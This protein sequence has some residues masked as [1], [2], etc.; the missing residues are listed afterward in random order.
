MIYEVKSNEKENRNTPNYFGCCSYSGF[1]NGFA[2]YVCECYGYWRNE[3]RTP[4]QKFVT[5]LN[6][7]NENHSE[8][9]N[10]KKS[11]GSDS[12]AEIIL[13]TSLGISK[14]IDFF[15]FVYSN[16]TSKELITSESLSICFDDIKIYYTRGID[17]KI[18]VEVIAFADGDFSSM[19]KFNDE[20]PLIL[21]S[22]RFSD[23][24]IEAIRE[25]HKGQGFM[26]N[27]RVV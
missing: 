3:K 8:K 18:S 19:A 12:Y 1:D 10:I 21:G 11:E 27:G 15:Y 25:R 9:I 20:V 5:L 4:S 16:S 14:K 7:Y 22:Y 23:E 24:E 2:L 6:E 26:I 17:S 13:K